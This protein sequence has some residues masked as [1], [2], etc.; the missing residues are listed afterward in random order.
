MGD[1]V[2]SNHSLL[3]CGQTL[4]YS[5]VCTIAYHCCYTNKCNTYETPIL[6]SSSS[7]LVILKR[8][9]PIFNMFLICHWSLS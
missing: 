5:S 8:I 1:R 6:S 2:H 7:S 4:I 3:N 9:V